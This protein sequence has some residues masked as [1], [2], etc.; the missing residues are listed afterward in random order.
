MIGL[1]IV[2]DLKSQSIVVHRLSNF[3]LETGRGG[4]RTFATDPFTFV[5]DIWK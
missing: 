4:W 2:G 3:Q 1:P 5:R